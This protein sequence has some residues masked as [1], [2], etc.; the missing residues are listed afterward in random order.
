MTDTMEKQRRAAL[1]LENARSDFES[2]AAEALPRFAEGIPEK[3]YD[4]MRYSLFA[5][6]KRLRPALCIAGGEA[7]GGSREP[8]L[9]MGLAL[10]MFHT[11]S[12][13]HDDLPCMDNDTI[14]RGKPTNHMVFGE[15]MALLAGGALFVW[16]LHLLSRE[17]PTW[18][19]SSERVLGSV[20]LFAEAI[21]PYG[22]CGGQ[23]LDLVG[24]NKTAEESL[25]WEIARKKTAALIRVSV[26]CGALL[27][28]ASTEDLAKIG[29]YG[30]H[31]GLAFQIIDDILDV[32]SS[33]EILGKTPGKDE[34][35]EKQ[36]FV[37]QYG[38]EGAKVKA[39]DETER[40]LRALDG[41]PEKGVLPDIPRFLETR[42]A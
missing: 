19:L 29:A 2:Y 27:G 33:P 16:P 23:A 34:L 35:L 8:L 9:L 30:E 22:V 37:F 5:G 3:L 31:L 13:I 1:F 18:N 20:S 6:G 41:L 32:I 25:T 28:G 7:F 11:G 10:E 21:G 17:L 39:R 12:L 38:L 15:G 14:R 36:T 26:Q 24:E 4:A 42:I 40:A